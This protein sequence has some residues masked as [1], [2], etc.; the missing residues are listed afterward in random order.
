MACVNEHATALALLSL[1]YSAV[2]ASG[3]RASPQ[4]Q[5]QSALPQPQAAAQ[6]S[7]PQPQAE[8]P[9]ELESLVRHLG[10]QLRTTR[11]VEEELARKAAAGEPIKK[12]F[13][14]AAV[15]EAGAQARPAQAVPPTPVL[16]PAPAAGGCCS[17]A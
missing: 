16:K 4:A 1:V 15:A 6:P 14:A 3:G 12:L 17:L 2:R 9:D 5:R 10:Q 7:Q 13:E 8:A 11:W